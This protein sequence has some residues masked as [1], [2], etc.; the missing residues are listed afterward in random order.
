MNET[1]RMLELRK[2]LNTARA[3]QK[4]LEGLVQ[5]IHLDCEYIVNVACGWAWDEGAGNTHLTSDEVNLIV[6]EEL[7]KENRQ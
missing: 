2:Q 5:Q 1:K 3:Y 7:A 4:Q 6:E